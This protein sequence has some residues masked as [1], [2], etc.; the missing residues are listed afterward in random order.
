[1]G[2]ENRTV[3]VFLDRDGV[4]NVDR[5]HV[6]DP[7]N[8]ELIPGAVQACRTLHEAGFKLIV[9]TNQA[10]IGR[11]L[12]TAAQ[13]HEFTA[14][15]EGVFR[16]AG[17][18]ITYTYHCP[19]HPTQGLGEYQMICDCRKPAPGM[20]LRAIREHG[21]D[22][23]GSFLVGDKQS[24]IDAA[25]AAGVRGYL[26]GEGRDYGSLGDLVEVLL[27]SNSSVRPSSLSSR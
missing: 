16:E 3:A 2:S 22:P 27:E 7:A 23:H 14:W 15:I 25:S 17:A 6:H 24:D 9:V 11:G 21:I 26:V 1:M 12:Y 4:I 8:F 10:G 13:F 20:L 5:G 18:P 19:H